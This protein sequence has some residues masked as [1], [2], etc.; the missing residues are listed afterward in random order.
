M[1][2]SWTG[3]LVAAALI[4][5]AGS[6]LA[7]YGDIIAEKSGMGRAW[8]GLIMMSAITS[9]PE[10]ITGISSVLF[11]Q[12][13]DLALGDI[14]GSCVFNLLILALLDFKIP[15]KPISSVIT[16]THIMA[17]LL[18]IL[19]MALTVIS[20]LYG[21]HFPN[22]AWFSTSS[23]LLLLLY[24][25]AIQLIHEHEKK[26]PP[27]TLPTVQLTRQPIS[28]N[29][30]IKKYLLFAL[31]VVGSATL[32]PY[33]AND[34][35]H[36]TGIATAFMG[37]LFVAA[38][39]SMPELV[40]SIAAVRIG[41]IN[42]AAGNLLGS[43]IF[44][45]FILGIDDILYTKGALLQ[46]VNPTHAVSGLFA[47]I[48]TTIAGIGIIY[49]APQKRFWLGIDALLII[50]LYIILISALFYYS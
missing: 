23:L 44:N 32:L 31:L 43:N 26:Q 28:I 5:Y 27:D 6:R 3:F 19:M 9:L 22:F 10:L 30:A 34:I 21:H 18:F 16:K 13:P 47:I 36:K 42:I 35:A 14:M 37:T 8:F 7:I 45:L 17:G 25:M 2:L 49:S 4:I 39:T 33:F 46:A 11:I 24:V 1:L 15:G 29:T 50:L 41:S 38:V 20:I 12:S 48:M 40:V